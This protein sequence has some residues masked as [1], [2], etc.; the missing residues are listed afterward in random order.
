MYA[1]GEIGRDIPISPWN[2][3]KLVICKQ[4]DKSELD[5][6]GYE[7]EGPEEILFPNSDQL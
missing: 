2:D 1:E 4:L 5:K 7:E 3:D 6:L